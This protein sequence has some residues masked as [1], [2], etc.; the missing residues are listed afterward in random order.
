LSEASSQKI[1]EEKDLKI[2]I[3]Y[4][5]MKLMASIFLNFEKLGHKLT[6]LFLA[7]LEKAI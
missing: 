2:L 4:P 5:A 1:A 6:A 7:I 3:A